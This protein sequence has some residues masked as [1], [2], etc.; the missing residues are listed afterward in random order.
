MGIAPSGMP[1]WPL[2]AFCTMSTARKRRVSMQR[3]SSCA[4]MPA[5]CEC[6]D[7]PGF[8]RGVPPPCA[9]LPDQCVG[10]TVVAQLRLLRAFELA[11]CLLGEHLAQFDAPL[12]EA[13]DVPDHALHE[14][15]VL[16]QRDE[17]AERMRRQAVGEDRAAG[18]VALEGAMRHQ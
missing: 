4:D 17:R 5:P 15:A 16:V 6:D 8:L 7:V 1:G 14:H 13:V 11:R 10:G 3:W 2:S 9:V 18:A 12:V